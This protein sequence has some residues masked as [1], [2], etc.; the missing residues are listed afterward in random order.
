MACSTFPSGF[1]PHAI[2]VAADAERRSLHPI[3]P[4]EYQL[5]VRGDLVSLHPSIGNWNHP[6][7]SHYVIRDNNVVWAE[8]MLPADIK[9]GRARDDA[10]KAAY[11]GAKEKGWWRKLL[12]WIKGLFR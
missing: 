3:R 8:T 10:E 6:C 2:R 1:R 11:F 7:Q 4:T 5:T 9:R 12:H